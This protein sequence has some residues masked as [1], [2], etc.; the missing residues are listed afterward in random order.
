MPTEY[1]IGASWRYRSY[2]VTYDP[3]FGKN[4][5]FKTFSGGTAHQVFVTLHEAIRYLGEP[6]LEK[7]EYTP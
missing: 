7:W 2:R 1:P 4:Y 5:P 3:T 6:L